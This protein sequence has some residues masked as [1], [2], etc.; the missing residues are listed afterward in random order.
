MDQWL[1]RLPACLTGSKAVWQ[2]SCKERS[3]R[4]L[5]DTNEL[6]GRRNP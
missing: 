6:K 3:A 4:Q 1:R 2:A 5:P